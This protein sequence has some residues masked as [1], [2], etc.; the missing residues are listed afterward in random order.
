MHGQGPLVYKMQTESE[1]VEI[2][3]E[4]ILNSEIYRQIKKHIDDKVKLEDDDKLWEELEKVVLNESREFASRLRLLTGGNLKGGEYHTALL[5]KC[6][7]NPTDMTVLLGRTKGTISHRRE[8]IG[9]KIYGENIGIKTID[10]IIRL[11]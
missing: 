11:L 6:G 8:S 3:S 5:V 10:N 4:G 2:T 9:M 1:G 7:I